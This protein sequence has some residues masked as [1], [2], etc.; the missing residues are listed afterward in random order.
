M[1]KILFFKEMPDNYENW[2]IKAR[3]LWDERD[4]DALAEHIEAC[5]QDPVIFYD[6]SCFVSLCVGKCYPV[7][8]PDVQKILDLFE[9][10]IQTTAV[11]EHAADN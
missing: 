7:D 8:N 10:K 11:S 4:M 6:L 1:E 3:A 2:R 9:K 5:P